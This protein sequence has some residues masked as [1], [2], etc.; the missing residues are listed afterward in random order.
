MT[1]AFATMVQDDGQTFCGPWRCP[2]NM[3]S[4]QTYG[5]HASVHDDETARKMGFAAGPIEGPTHFS[6]FVPLCCRVLGDRWLSRGALSVSYKT[7]VLEGEEVRA[8]IAKPA[9]GATQ[10]PIWMVKRDGTEVLRGT[11]SVDDGNPPS[12][13]EAKLASLPSPDPRRVIFRH[14]APG[15]RRPRLRAI[16]RLDDAPGPLYPFTLREKLSSITEPSGLY[17][18]GAQTPWG[19]AIIPVEMISVLVHH[20]ADSDPWLPRKPTID[21]FVDQ[22]IRLRK[23]PLMVGQ[24]YDIERTVIALSAS[25]RTESCW[26]RS[27]I[28]HPGGE[29]V[30]ATMIL[31]VASFKDSYPDYERE[32]AGL[33]V[34]EARANQ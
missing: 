25:K 33:G 12:A 13:V 26:V 11:A 32:L 19:G 24:E 4:K 1:S 3:L 34:A 17:E 21:L 9:S 14:V 20:V 29:E 16:L 27:E 22:E 31:N 7:A 23:G 6:Q 10:V 8:F 2:H 30:L 15:A 18:P 5:G 28:F